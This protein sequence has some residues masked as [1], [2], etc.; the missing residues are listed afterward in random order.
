MRQTTIAHYFVNLF[1]SL[2]SNSMKALLTTVIIFISIFAV[3]QKKPKLFLEKLSPTD[4]I[5]LHIERI[6]CVITYLENEA[7][8]TIYMDADTIKARAYITIPVKPIEK[9][10]SLTNE[11]Y[12]YLKQLEIHCRQKPGAPTS[13]DRYEWKYK[14]KTFKT[15]L[16]YEAGNKLMSYFDDTFK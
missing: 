13:Y 16:G 3:A 1:Y 10:I 9:I 4:T 2:L 11:Q 7:F 6:G 5:R 12:E 15:R 14:K 8:F